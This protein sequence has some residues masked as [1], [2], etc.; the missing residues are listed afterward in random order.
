MFAPSGGGQ[1]VVNTQ[2]TDQQFQQ[3]TIGH[4]PFLDGNEPLSFVRNVQVSPTGNAQFQVGGG[5]SVEP[6]LSVLSVSQLTEVSFAGSRPTVNAGSSYMIDMGIASG[7]TPSIL[8]RSDSAPNDHSFVELTAAFHATG[9]LAPGDSARI[10]FHA[11]FGLIINQANPPHRLW[12][13]SED[14]NI[15]DTGKFNASLMAT[16][17]VD[18]LEYTTSPISI[19]HGSRLPINSGINFTLRRGELSTARSYI[20]FTDPTFSATLLN[21]LP[22]TS[23]LP[24]PTS[25]LIFGSTVALIASAPLFRR[26]IRRRPRLHSRLMSTREIWEH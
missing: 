3:V 6:L 1:S 5:W 24:E 13:V 4:T 20:G 7:G 19:L 21:G 11:D 26:R 14:W 8:Y 15:T 9:E 23:H 17:F 25:F 22:P 2:V 12:L 18:L 10:H 16:T